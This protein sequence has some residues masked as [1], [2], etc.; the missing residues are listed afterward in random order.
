[1]TTADLF[2]LTGLLLGLIGFSTAIAWLVI[3]TWGE[4]A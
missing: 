4:Q 2:A 1:M 3:R